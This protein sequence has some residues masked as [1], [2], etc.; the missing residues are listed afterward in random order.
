M[1]GLYVLATKPFLVTSFTNISSHSIGCV[2][3]FVYGFLCSE[4]AYK[5]KSHLFIF[6]FLS[7]SL[8]DWP[9]K[10]LIQFMLKTIF[11]IFSSRSFMMSRLIFK[12]FSHFSVDF[13]VWCEEIFSLHWFACALLY[14]SIQGSLL[15]EWMTKSVKHP[16]PP[17]VIRHPAYLSHRPFLHPQA[18]PSPL[19]SLGGTVAG[20]GLAPASSLSSAAAGLLQATRLWEPA[21]L[22][23]TQ[24]A[25]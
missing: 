8:E 17:S 3:H 2:F 20:G 11:R 12:T 10:T 21:S 13:C 14:V 15:N 9:H 6:A 25:I 23:S 7:F 16:C 1:N 22:P 5:F 24:R 19:C 4:K 18:P